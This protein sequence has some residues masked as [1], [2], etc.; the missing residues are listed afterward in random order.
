VIFECSLYS[1]GV[2][3]RV[4][5][6]I[7]SVCIIAPDILKSRSVI[8]EYSFLFYS[9][10]LPWINESPMHFYIDS[11]ITVYIRVR[12]HVLSNW[13]DWT[14]YIVPQFYILYHGFH[15]TIL[16]FVLINCWSLESNTVCACAHYCMCVWMLKHKK[17]I[18]NFWIHRL[19]PWK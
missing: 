14:Y 9:E 6:I 2:I 16:C 3:R 17:S 10:E 7:E 8:L 11:S 15:I 18:R 19:I 12:K 5:V 4:T 13:Y 1:D